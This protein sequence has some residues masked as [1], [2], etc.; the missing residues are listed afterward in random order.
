MGSTNIK[1]A[2]YRTDRNIHRFNINTF[3]S[4]DDASLVGRHIVKPINVPTPV[5]CRSR[6]VHFGC[7]E[8]EF[9]YFDA[10]VVLH[11]Q[12]AIKIPVFG[13][14]DIYYRGILRAFSVFRLQKPGVHLV[15]G[16][17]CGG[18]VVDYAYKGE[19]VRP[20]LEEKEGLMPPNQPTS[21]NVPVWVQVVVL[22]CVAFGPWITAWI[23][24]L[25]TG[26][27]QANRDDGNSLISQHQGFIDRILR[28]VEA[29]PELVEANA[30]LVKINEERR[31]ENELLRQRVNELENRIAAVERDRDA[32]RELGQQVPNLQG[33]IATYERIV[34]EKMDEIERLVSE[35][36]A[37]RTELARMQSISIGRTV[38]ENAHVEIAHTASPG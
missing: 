26:R 36:D 10:L 25:L 31:K 5:A 3:R 4:V 6:R 15:D 21:W 18:M 17:C 19:N 1:A 28:G 30:E 27:R 12:G 35:R 7:T 33:Q 22:I 9:G 23:N 24:H 11:G 38:I 37:A 34:K 2:T 14:V 16:I 13:V 8:L 29:V 20:D 32:W